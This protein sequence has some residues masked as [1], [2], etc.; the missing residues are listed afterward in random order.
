M[1]S[2]P[3]LLMACMCADGET[4]AHRMEYVKFNLWPCSHILHNLRCD[5]NRV[6]MTI[7]WMCGGIWDG[8][9]ASQNG[10]NRWVVKG[11]AIRCVKP[12]FASI[13]HT[14]AT[15]FDLVVEQRMFRELF[16]LMSWRQR[17]RSQPTWIR[18]QIYV[19]WRPIQS[20]SPFFPITT[21][22]L[23]LNFRLHLKFLSAI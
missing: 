9:A 1:R 23:A 20:Q 7:E 8:L 3:W 15:S 14:A 5:I 13:S 12:L 19:W 6:N 4:S 10:I 2:V 17:K 11:N 16:H 22:E 21:G 18:M